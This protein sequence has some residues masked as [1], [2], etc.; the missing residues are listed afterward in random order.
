[1]I[2]K[3]NEFV[4]DSTFNLSS[5]LD[6]LMPS[7]IMDFESEESDIYSVDCWKKVDMG[8]KL[9]DP[10]LDRGHGSGDWL[11]TVE[12][13]LSAQ[14]FLNHDC[15]WNG[16]CDDKEHTEETKPNFG[17]VVPKPP[18]V[19]KKDVL[20]T[21]PIWPKQQ[22]VLKPQVNRQTSTVV[23]SPTRHNYNTPP[24]SDDEDM[25]NNVLLD[26]L[27]DAIDECDSDLTEYFEREVK[28]EE[29]QEEDTDIKEE[30]LDDIKEEELED[31]ESEEEETP[32]NNFEEEFRI[33]T[34]LAAVND[35]SYHKDKNAVMRLNYFGLETPSDSGKDL[36]IAFCLLVLVVFFL[37]RVNAIT[38][39]F[40][41]S[42][43]YYIRGSIEQK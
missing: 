27:K 7:S 31:T 19:V 10:V 2:D 22:S 30:F 42:Q 17:C 13:Q 24:D 6:L 34:K 9:E 41:V 20:L 21:E 3:M 14:R 8:V 38:A 23:S 43:L 25:K 28:E 11:F 37:V 18:S 39:T 40:G 35:H 26:L 32:E 1:M 36:L 15:M 4:S 5:Y 33:R 16:L 29:E 12:P